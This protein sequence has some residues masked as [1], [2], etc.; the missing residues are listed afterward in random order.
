MPAL[1]AEF[2]RRQAENCVRVARQCFDL[3]A[4]ERLRI[5]ATELH[6]KADEIDDEQKDQ[7]V[8]PA[9]MR[10]NGSS[11]GETDHG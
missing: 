9:I 1:T 2:L 10:R 3:A 11:N 4:S 6:A 5:M 8:S 7:A